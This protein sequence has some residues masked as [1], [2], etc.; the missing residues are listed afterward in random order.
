MTLCSPGA[1]SAASPRT[2]RSQGGRCCEGSLCG[3]VCSPVPAESKPAAG[4]EKPGCADSGCEAHWGRKGPVALP[5][6]AQGRPGPSGGDLVPAEGQVLSERSVGGPCWPWKPSAWPGLS[7][8]PSSSPVPPASSPREPPGGADPP[9]FFQ[10]KRG[11]I[12]LTQGPT[13][14]YRHFHPHTTSLVSCVSSPRAPR[15]GC[16]WESPPWAQLGPGRAPYRARGS[17]LSTDARPCRCPTSGHTGLTPG[18]W[19]CFCFHQEAPRSLWSLSVA[20]R[21]PSPRPLASRSPFALRL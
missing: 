21:N 9:H 1:P 19:V 16:L 3:C 12:R 8:P 4:P 11:A 17:V 13:S 10:A 15:P 2:A 7:T 18:P 6:A 5:R 14:K 20:S